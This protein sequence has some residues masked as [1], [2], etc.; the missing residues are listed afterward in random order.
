MKKER[1]KKMQ[2]VVIAMS[3]GRPIVITPYGTRKSSQHVIEELA[4]EY[5]QR[6]DKRCPWTFLTATINSVATNGGKKKAIYA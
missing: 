3:E 6:W 1:M 2:P 5:R 4:N